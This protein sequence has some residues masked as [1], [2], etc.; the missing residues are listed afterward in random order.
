MDDK[1]FLKLSSTNGVTQKK[2]TDWKKE[3][4]I[5]NLKENFELARSSH[6]TQIN[7]IK[8][9]NELR[10]VEGKYACKKITGRSSIQ[11]KLIRRQVEWRYSALTEPF[12]SSQKLFSVSPVTFEDVAAAKQNELLLNY[13]FKT[14][15]NKVKFIDDY[16]R[17]TI[18]DGTSIIRIGWEREV[19]EVEEEVPV[20]A[21]YPVQDE[22]HIQTLQEA[23][24]LKKANPRI[25]E[26]Q[27]SDE[28]KASVDF[29]I[30]NRQPVIA[31]I[32]GK[33]LV[34]TEKVLINR[35]TVELINP[36]NIIIDPSC[37]GDF[38]KALFAIVSFETNK[39]DLLKQSNRYQNIDAINWETVS[40]SGD[41][42]HVSQTPTEFEFKDASRKK[43]IAYEYW[44]FYDIHDDGKLVPIVATWIGD[45]LIRLE[46]N[47]F[48]D[49]KLPF[50][51]VPY[52]PIKRELYGET[53]A[54][55]LEDNQKILGAVSRG[56]ID[57]LGRSANS[58][59]GIAKGLLDPV[60]K[61]RYESGQ[62]YEFNPSGN[63]QSQIIEHKYPELPQS[64]LQMLN[65]Q[66]QEAEA[67]TGV[68]S[69]SGGLSGN[70]YGNVATG[71]RGMLD[72]ASK[73]EM[74]IL[75][76]L[77][78][79]IIEVGSKIISMNYAFLSEKEVIRITNA[80]FATINREDLKGN[81]DLDV[82]ISTAEVDEAKSK[83]LGFMLQTIGPNVGLEITLKIL[84]EIADLKR[85][86]DLAEELRNYKPEPD[87]MNEQMKQIELA[88]AQAEVE[89]IQAQSQLMMA[90]AAYQNAQAKLANVSAED[91]A[92][93][94][95]HDRDMEH[96]K[97]QAE[98]NQN[99]EVTKALLKSKKPEESSPN[100]EAA[101]GYNQI[102]KAS[103]NSNS[104]ASQIQPQVQ[105]QVDPA[106][107]EQ[108][109]Y[110]P[111]EL[112][113]SNSFNNPQALPI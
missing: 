21:F 53:D 28:L 49:Q 10:N 48:P 82:D 66:N 64:A 68:K 98:G 81:F 11:P 108:G 3:P 47:P 16:V 56:M 50:V 52:L 100:I 40:V 22:E 72:A 2:L 105:P 29:F 13:Q 26:D 33:E 41:A 90:Q 57:L 27:I 34:K 36:E 54:E 96:M 7:K 92:T 60:N 51:L 6:S 79:G 32:T 113:Q 85:M 4:T 45:I 24:E 5:Q 25:Y 104:L 67:L 37:N 106:L 101:I 91:M 61:R 80:E 74:A 97:A 88:K 55:L 44:G 9:W 8:S 73:R 75:R 43:T 84:S 111:P 20:Y 31:Q 23:V 76:R 18:D 83:D 70:A 93:G 89:R 58:Q 46:E 19:E 77:A 94:V 87:P 12:L 112:D 103:P 42:D 38:S 59:I 14:Q 63:P 71:I 1:N 99:L 65:L 39:A 110:Y 69:F 17:S 102:S 86:P 109:N 107:L 78:K 35:P 15:L 30:E 95:S 62:D